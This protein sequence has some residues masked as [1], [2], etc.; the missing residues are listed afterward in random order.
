[1][2][3][4]CSRPMDGVLAANE[5]AGMLGS[6]FIVPQDNYFDRALPYE[7]HPNIHLFRFQVK[8]YRGKIFSATSEK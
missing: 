8:S 7:Q 3:I 1:M 6:L 2:E 5:G 4:T